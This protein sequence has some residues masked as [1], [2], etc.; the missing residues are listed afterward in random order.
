[1]C[2]PHLLSISG[3]VNRYR[4]FITVF[5]VPNEARVSPTMGNAKG[6]SVHC[7]QQGI[8]TMIAVSPGLIYPK[9]N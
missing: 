9:D 1:M 8:S 3:K 6:L 2:P 4:Y 5:S 7:V